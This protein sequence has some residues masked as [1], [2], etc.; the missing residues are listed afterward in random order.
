MLSEFKITR[1]VEFAETDLAGIMHFSNFFRFMETAEHAFFR[2]LGYS[3]HTTRLDPP[4]CWPRVHAE[5]DYKRPLKFEDEVEVHLLVKE[6]RSKTIEY[7]FV[8]RK[9]GAQ[10]EEVA[11]GALVVASVTRN[12]Q[13]QLK[14]VPIPMALAEQIA[15]APMG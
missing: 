12:A 13:G 7:V 3:I 11:R 15:A 2:A 9:L 6:I 4:V 10:V 14:S 8:F 1:R 5:C